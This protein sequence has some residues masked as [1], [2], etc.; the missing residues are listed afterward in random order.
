[1]KNP[2]TLRRTLFCT[3][4]AACIL[5][6]PHLV[7]ASPPAAPVTHVLNTLLLTEA[8]GYRFV[9]TVPEQPGHAWIAPPQDWVSAIPNGDA[10]I[11]NMP[12]YTDA[13]WLN[14]YR[15]LQAA[16]KKRHITVTQTTNIP[17]APTATK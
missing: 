12:F 8:K 14:Q 11:V 2:L 5:S 17:I 7:A 4:T 3:L 1:M 16:C 6:V 10:L 15:A 9:W 13:R